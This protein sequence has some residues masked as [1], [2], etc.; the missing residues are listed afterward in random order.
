MTASAV[1]QAAPAPVETAAVQPEAAPAA[2][3][4]PKE[5]PGTAS[6]SNLPTS[7][8]VGTDVVALTTFTTRE[9]VDSDAGRYAIELGGAES[10]LQL[11]RRDGSW[12]C[13]LRYQ[14]PGEPA[15]RLVAELTLE[16]GELRSSDGRFRI[17]ATDDDELLVHALGNDDVV[18]E[19]LWVLY[20]RR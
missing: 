20:E 13:A 10:S 12:S 18:P 2:P 19:S 3:E 1:P 15:R 16:D 11:R 17:R 4:A 8:L 6:A 14:E 5:P 7:V 9:I